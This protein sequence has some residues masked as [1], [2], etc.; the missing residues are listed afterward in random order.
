MLRIRTPQHTKLVTCDRNSKANPYKWKFV[1][2]K[3]TG[4]QEPARTDSSHKDQLPLI[5]NK[6][7]QRG[8]LVSTVEQNRH[9]PKVSVLQRRQSASS[10][11]R[12]A[13]TVLGIFITNLPD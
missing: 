13:I 3:E 1:N 6:E 11:G 5:R 9:I 4:N 10:V 7:G 2:Y 8:K 12:K